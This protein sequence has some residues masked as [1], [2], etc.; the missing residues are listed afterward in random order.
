VRTEVL[1]VDVELCREEM[2]VAVLPR[3]EATRAVSRPAGSRDGASSCAERLRRWWAR[4]GL[5]SMPGGTVDD[6]SEVQLELMLLREQ[7]MRLLNDRHRPF[8]LGA[9]IDQLRLRMGAAHQVTSDDE[10]WA[11]LGE[12]LLL[13]ENLDLV[14]DELDA[15]IRHVR[16]Q[17][18]SGLPQPALDAGISSGTSVADAA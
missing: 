14:I 16:A 11:L 10:A 9:L 8:D 5:G 1:V 17:L 12:Y 3:S 4:L 7:N 18:P 13:R 15:V 2:D 6:A